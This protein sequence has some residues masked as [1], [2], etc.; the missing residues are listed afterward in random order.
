MA[1][2]KKIKRAVLGLFIA[3]SLVL[4]WF[5]IDNVRGLSLITAEW[6]TASVA[7]TSIGALIILATLI[8]ALITLYSIKANETPF[9]MKNVKRLRAMAILLAIYEPYF[10]INQIVFR[11]LYPIVLTDGISIEVHSTIG[12]VVLAAGLVVYC[13]SL[14]FEYGISLQQQ[15][16]ETL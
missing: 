6:N 10:L 8:I 5:I 7:L 12:G 3:V 2:T 4:L 16:D 13:V 11:K 9:N 14:V 15:F 1:D